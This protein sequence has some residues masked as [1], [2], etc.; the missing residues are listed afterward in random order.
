[1][2]ALLIHKGIKPRFLR[3]PAIIC[4]RALLIH[5][6]TKQTMA[7]RSPIS[8]AIMDRIIHSSYEVLIDGKLSMRE[9][10][11]LKAIQKGGIH[12]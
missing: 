3:C 5:K 1:M 8:E 2:R 7:A 12:E 10:D 11:G 9:R 4:L 6:G